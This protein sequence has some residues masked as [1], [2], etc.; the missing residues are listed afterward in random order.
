MHAS[1]SARSLG[2][3]WLPV[4]IPIGPNLATA[5]RGRS[6]SVSRNRQTHC[7]G[8]PDTFRSC[9][10]QSSVRASSVSSA[11]EL[12]VPFAPILRTEI[13]SWSRCRSHTTASASDE[14]AAIGA[15]TVP[16]IGQNVSEVPAPEARSL[17]HS[18]NAGEVDEQNV[19]KN[20]EGAEE[21]QIQT[22]QQTFATS[23]ETQ[24]QTIQQT[25]ATSSVESEMHV[26]NPDPE[27]R[28]TCDE[29][30]QAASHDSEQPTPKES[31]G[32]EELAEPTSAPTP[33]LR[34]E[35]KKE[36][37]LAKVAQD[38]ESLKKKLFVFGKSPMKP[39]SKQVK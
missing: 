27:S 16:S 31:D 26:H 7:P 14:G 12:T 23:E 2:S 10:S 24:I 13:R 1:G 38:Q 39:G 29:K 35:T 17:A 19:E 33:T 6:R 34:A 36:E 22:I 18:T 20:D 3:H 4:T 28:S 21:I 15:G 32:K 11:R 30:D 5:L 37:V 9:R 8:T 25:S